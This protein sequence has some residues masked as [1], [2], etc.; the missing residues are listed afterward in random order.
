ISYLYRNLTINPNKPPTAICQDITVQLSATGT[1]TILAADVD[2]GSFD[3]EGPVS[4]SISRDT[5][6]CADIGS[7]VKV[8]LRVTDAQGSS[9]SCL[10]RVTVVDTIV[11]VI[12]CSANIIATNDL[13][14]CGAVVNYTLPEATDNCSEIFAADPLVNGS[15]ENNYDGWTIESS[16]SIFGILSL[17]Q[18]VRTGD[19]LY[20][21]KDN[22]NE[23]ILS[24]NFNYTASP[25]NGNKL[26]V[27]TQTNSANHRMYQDVVLP[28]RNSLILSFDLQYRNLADEGFDVDNQYF[29]VVLRDPITDDIVAEIYKTVQGIDLLELPMM[30]TKAFDIS[31]FKGQTVR[32]EMISAN[33]QNF[34]FDIFLDNISIKSDSVLQLQQTAGLVSG[35]VFPVGTT[36]NT[37]VAT[38]A[39]GNTASCSFDVVVAD[40]EL[41]VVVT[42]PVTVQLSASG[43]ASITAAQ[44]NN[45]SSDNCGIA[46][47]AIDIKDFTCA[48][49]GDNT[50][51]L[52]VTDVNGNVAT[53]TAIVTVE[54]KVAP[55]VVTKDITIQLNASGTASI[56]AADVNN[57]S[58]DA[59]GISLVELDKTSFTCANVGDNTVTL[60]VTDINGNVA[61]QTAIV[62]VEDK[63]A[64]EVLTNGD[65]NVN[66]DFNVCGATVV[67][68]AS[69]TDNCSV[70]T[71]TG[72]RNDALAL[73]AVYPVGTTTITWTVTDGSG[74]KA[75]STQIVT[76]VDSQN[77]TIATLSAINVNADAG[78]CTYASIQ[79]AKPTATDNC[80]VVSVV[81][82]PASLVSGSNTVT[83]TV[84]D[85]AGLKAISTQTVTVVD[86][87][88]PVVVT[89]NKTIQL[90]ASGTASIVAADV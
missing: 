81:V 34:Y 49:V 23:E 46:S 5:F 10:A 3:T 42:K 84:T 62:R 21:F 87:E 90:N 67:V 11:P 2:G 7:A 4:L 41:P 88:A 39:S 66:T 78:V 1:A 51:T 19:F 22:Q 85:G 28:D 83:W 58:T 69:A 31:S 26:A 70:D 35:S 6:S 64:P 36:T 17:G 52:T 86:N 9:A 89:K 44:I 82:S 38:D 75:T 61:M 18:T 25:T 71:P 68:S 27:F 77:P 80:S 16:R 65:K 43:Q 13:G 47:Y 20:D 73:D 63:I 33:I 48:N 37:F 32:L 12:T 30:T 50:V 15:F 45:A 40:T 24:S 60:T 55:V 56:V 57:G 79:L 53:Q 29:S 74:Q 59:C 76:V 72:V 8:I 14:L 54:D